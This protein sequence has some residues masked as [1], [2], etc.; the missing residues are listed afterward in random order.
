MKKL[1]ALALSLSLC[2]GLLT[3][4][5]SQS[6]SSS[7]GA[8]NVST[9]SSGQTELEENGVTPVGTYPI[10]T[11]PLTLSIMGRKDPGAPDWGELEI[12][13][14]LTDITGISFDFEMSET[15]SF[16]EQK[17]IALVG[18]QY[19]GMIWRDAASAVT[20]EE[21]YGPQGIFLD[22][23]DLIDK[24]A[25]N[26]KA[27][28]EKRPDVKAAITALDGKVYGLPYVFETATTEGHLSF[29]DSRWMENVG[30]AKVPETTDELYEMLKAF[31]EKDANGNG[32]PDDEIP[33]SCVG[34]DNFD[35]R[36][37]MITAFTGL[38]DGLGFN[39]SDDG[40]VVYAPATQEYKSFLEYARKLYAEG[41]LDAEF[42]T[43]TPQQHQAKV[44]G[45]I[46]GIYCVSP[47]LLDPSTTSQQLS[48]PPL[49]S[50]TNSKKV[51]KGPDGVNPGRAFITDKCENPIAAIRLIDMFYATDDNAVEGFCGQTPF[52]G[53]ENET[54]KYTDSTKTVYEWIAPITGFADIN[55]TVSVT[56]HLPGYLSFLAMPSG[57]PLMEMK[58]TQVEKMQKPYYTDAYPISARF[59]K[60]ESDR[61]NMIE[62]DLKNY[63]L[64][65]STK[66]ITGEESIDNFDSYLSTIEK[67]GLPEL[68][69]I[70]TN[71]Y[72]R[73]KSA[74]DN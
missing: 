55:K 57:N 33:F 60:E 30:I 14:R 35:I 38:P 31:K 45:G 50:A 26:L 40:E 44:K 46:V 59:N 52:L 19:P 5:G 67:T 28:L 22:L 62:N 37:M 20:D 34:L 72:A 74:F 32:D 64:M 42:S 15:E 24:Y 8:S 70:K 11:E 47:T 12:F 6:S 21:T 48:L 4:C 23:T 16:D 7:G 66:F 71:A 27:F 49:T 69:T 2:A 68:L 73:W 29:F 41:L 51:L 63:V 58:V 25:P 54:W 13:K 65:M 3:A 18:G 39:I 56:M 36:R 61:G 43:Q 10:V 53:W 1:L 17:N 9:S